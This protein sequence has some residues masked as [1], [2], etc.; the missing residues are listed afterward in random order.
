MQL[1]WDLD[2]IFSGGSHSIALADFL[3]HLATQLADYEANLLPPP[4]NALSQSVWVT[5][6]ETL[7]QL[8]MRADQANSFIGCLVSQNVKDDHALKLEAQIDQLRAQLGTIWTRLSASF[9]QQPDAAW[10]ALLEQTDLRAIAF[11][12]DEQRELARR[13]LSPDLEALANELA[14]NGYHGWG[15]LYNVISGSKQVTFKGEPLSL[16]QLQNKM[17]DDPDRATRQAAFTLF[18]EAWGEIAKPCAVALNNQAGFRLTLYR[19]RKWDSVLAEPLMRNRLNPE[20]LAVM[21]NVID[22]KSSKLLAYF[23]AKAKIMGVEKLSWCDVAAPVGQF[24]RT[25]TYPEAADFVVDNIRRFNPDIADYCR[26]AVDQQWVESENR[27]GKRGGAYCTDFP[28]SGQTRIF[29]T[30]NGTYNGMLTLAHELGHGYHAW[31]MRDLPHGARYYTMSVA[32]T[33]STFNELVVTNASFALATE[34][35]EQLSLLASKLNDAATM[36]MNIR[37]RFDFETAFFAQR[38]KQTL[39]VDEL[40]ELMLTAQKT[41]YKNGLAQYHP[42]F[43]AS[44][45]HFYATED[46]FYNFPYTFGYLFSNGIYQQAL[47]EGPSFSNRYIAL[48]RDTGSMSTE[49]LA[50]THLGIDLTRPEFWEATVDRI[51]A[52]V[53]NFVSLV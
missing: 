22:A 51:L 42:S 17:M 3:T 49:A 48:L 23:A 19:Q 10:H 7:Y 35:Q 16:G 47:A 34:P 25:F 31:V 32:E 45:L 4:L 40:N 44:K 11:H 53:D 15:R 46:P 37:S 33:A 24:N 30:Y 39:S 29:M 12:L 27:P 9:A 41:A 20:T 2:S 8:E 13:K 6:I 38:A 5:T 14:T 1:N 26:M 43:W 36:L 52:D 21:W 50:K 28:L 18:E